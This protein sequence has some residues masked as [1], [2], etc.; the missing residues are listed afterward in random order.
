MA[1]ACENSDLLSIQAL[2][3]NGAKPSQGVG[4][5]RMTPLHWAAAQG[6]YQLCEWLLDNKARV[7]SKDKFKRT[8]LIMAVRNGHTKVASL[9]LQ[10]GAD[11]K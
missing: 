10:R 2:F 9:L 8:P 5:N 7:L 3:E 1:I 6:N 11:W 4:S